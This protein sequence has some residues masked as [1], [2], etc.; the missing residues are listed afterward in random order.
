VYLSVQ[1]VSNRSL[2]DAAVALQGQT[3]INAL[4]ID[5]KGDRGDTPYPSAARV[6]VGA[7]PEQKDRVARINQFAAVIRQ[8]HLRG[9]YL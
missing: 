7:V 3:A 4:V 6:A 2:R 5:M 8:L 9:L 1:G